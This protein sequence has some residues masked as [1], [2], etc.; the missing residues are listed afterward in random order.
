VRFIY[1]YPETNGARADMLDA[2]PP[3]EL[4]AAAEAAGWHGFAFTEHPAPGARWLDA[5]GHQSLDP[6][7]ALG[8]IAAVTSTLRL[9]TNLAVGPYRNPLSLAKSVA[10]VDKLSNGRMIL[11]TGTGYL[12]GEFRALGV[13]F[14]ER[15]VLFDEMLDTL[16]LHWS[17]KPFS[18]EGKHFVAKDTIG[19]PHP[20]QDPI[21]IWIGGNSKLSLRRAATRAQGWLPM[22]AGTDISATTRTPHIGS[23]DELAAKIDELRELAGERFAELDITAS[24]T[25]SMVEPGADVQ[26]HRD[27]LARLEEIGVTWI[28]A[29]G[30]RENTRPF[31][32][33]FAARYIQ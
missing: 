13:D 33:E 3:A 19:L 17:G 20:V 24:Y 14:E 30:G 21:P 10:T 11:G 23:I 7:V 9:M 25:A 5:G 18:Y 8:H 28:I 1:Q 6:F 16:P 4:A 12:R 26:R 2:G 32:D 31:I 27:A 15:N 22:L 29:G